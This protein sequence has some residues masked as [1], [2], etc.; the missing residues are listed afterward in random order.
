MLTLI[1]VSNIVAISAIIF[2]VSCSNNVKKFQIPENDED[3]IF[4]I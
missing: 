4:I 3:Y 2:L 1:L